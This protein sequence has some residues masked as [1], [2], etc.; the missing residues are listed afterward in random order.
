M[1]GEFDV[2]NIEIDQ[3]KGMSLSESS[4][5]S[6]SSS[7]SNESSNDNQCDN[8]TKVMADIKISFKWTKDSIG[9][10]S[11]ADM[12]RIESEFTNSKG[13]C[14][15]YEERVFFLEPITITG[16]S[17]N[18]ILPGVYMVHRCQ[19]TKEIVIDHMCNE[20]V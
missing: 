4:S 20:L 1:F 2:H 13:M 10:L 11:N 19:C 8:N 15:M 7:S 12:K 16:Q 18:A 6:S 17:D 3:P 5:S 9:T 14:V